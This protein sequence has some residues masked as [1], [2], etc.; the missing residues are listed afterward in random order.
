MKNRL[1]IPCAFLEVFLVQN[2]DFFQ[3]DTKGD[4]WN[5]VRPLEVPPKVFWRCF[6]YFDHCSTCYRLCFMLYIRKR[7]GVVFLEGK[8]P[9]KR[10]TINWQNT[11]IFTA[12]GVLLNRNK[13]PS[14]SGSPGW[15]WWCC[16]QR[17]QPAQN[18]WVYSEFLIFF[19][20]YSRLLAD[21]LSHLGKWVKSIKFEAEMSF[22]CTWKVEKPQCIT[23]TP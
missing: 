15:Q 23:S 22:F 9:L 19:V 13:L 2:L 12:F 10:E 7:W 6:K 3:V 21:F 16:E 11:E 1:P 8:K 18:F 5:T 14:P 4:P 20:L 17:L